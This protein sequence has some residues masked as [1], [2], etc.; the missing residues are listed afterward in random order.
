[1]HCATVSNKRQSERGRP[2]EQN[3]RLSPMRMPS[4]PM[5]T[6]LGLR[7]FIIILVAA[8]PIAAQH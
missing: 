2:L 6:C 1:M 3:A 4:Q 5:H 7:L 8:V